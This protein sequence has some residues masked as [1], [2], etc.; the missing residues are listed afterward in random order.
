MIKQDWLKSEK[1]LI[2][3]LRVPF[4][5]NIERNELKFIESNNGVFTAI[6]KNKNTLIKIRERKGLCNQS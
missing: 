5:K 1:N 3:E 4:L 2:K 6:D